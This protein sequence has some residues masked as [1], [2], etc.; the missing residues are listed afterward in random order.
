M[1]RIKMK[2]G[3]EYDILYRNRG[4]RCRIWVRRMSAKVKRKYRRRERHINNAAM[5]YLVCTEV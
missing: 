2:T 1:K 3:D 5:V 4:D